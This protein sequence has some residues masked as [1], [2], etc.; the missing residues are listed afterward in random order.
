MRLSGTIEYLAGLSERI[1][2]HIAAAAPPGAGDEK[3]LIVRHRGGK[4]M[5]WNGQRRELQPAVALGVVGT[6][7]MPWHAAV[8][9][10]RGTAYPGERPCAENNREGEAGL[11]PMP[12]ATKPD[13]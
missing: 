12:V 10:G 2:H 13:F 1:G 4:S 5:P 11:V 3:Q 7:N 6:F 9:Y 8:V